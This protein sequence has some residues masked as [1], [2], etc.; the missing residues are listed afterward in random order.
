[1]LTNLSNDST[2]LRHWLYLVLYGC[3]VSAFC[4]VGAAY[5]L[6]VRWHKGMV[7]PSAPAPVFVGQSIAH[8]VSSA[9]AVKKAIRIEL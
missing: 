8:N 1:M 9:Y 6:R 3:E 5:G 7:L 4:A 2:S